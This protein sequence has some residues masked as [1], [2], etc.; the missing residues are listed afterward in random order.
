[1]RLI[2]KNSV[3]ILKIIK[4]DI[5]LLSSAHEAVYRISTRI[6]RSVLVIFLATCLQ[7]LLLFCFY[8]PVLNIFFSFP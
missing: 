3:H 2:Q 8:F 7:R 6:N 5:L 4:F 1:M